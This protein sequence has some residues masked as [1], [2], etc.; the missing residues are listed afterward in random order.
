MKKGVL[1]AFLCVVSVGAW[2]QKA[3][4]SVRFC[5]PSE[6]RTLRSDDRLSVRRFSGRLFDAPQRIVVLEFS[7]THFSLRPVQEQNRTRTSALGKKH[8]AEAAVN[9]GFFVTDPKPRNAAVANDFLKIDGAVCSSIPSPGWGA[10]AVGWNTDGRL[11]YTLW[12]KAMEADT[13]A[14]WSA[15]YRH[16]MA[17]GPMLIL[18]GRS[19]FGWQEADKSALNSSQRHDGYAPRTA[20]GTKRDGTVVL[21]AIDGRQSGAY[22][23]SFA[24]L[25]ALGRW[26]GLHDML[27]L[28]GGGS[29]ALWSRGQGLANTPSDGKWIF[30]IER[31]VANALLVMPKE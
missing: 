31:P 22:G 1:L 11:E 9:G 14:G 20:V 18:N 3:E 2:A 8:G 12:D 27:N 6:W 15:A 4:D 30:R 24:E 25:A 23:S 19:L 13:A 17:A 10:G 26:L 21:M 7:P 29:S 28:D 5:T 16:V